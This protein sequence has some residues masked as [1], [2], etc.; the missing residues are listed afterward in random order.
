MQG[1][2]TLAIIYIT[3]TN[4]LKLYNTPILKNKNNVFPI[5]GILVT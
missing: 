5:V 3:T 1:S 2:K 4:I